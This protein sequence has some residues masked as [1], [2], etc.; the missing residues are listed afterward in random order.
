M[1]E[2]NKT[3]TYEEAKLILITYVLGFILPYESPDSEA[4]KF[5]FSL[6][7]AVQK[8]PHADLNAL[9][10]IDYIF[11]DFFDSSF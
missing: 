6:I 4:V 3:L 10:D 7:P 2:S 9:C 1:K 11:E 8:S 5:Y